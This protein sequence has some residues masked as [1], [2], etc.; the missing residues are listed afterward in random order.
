VRRVEE[1]KSVKIGDHIGDYAS[2]LTGSKD[3]Q[4]K[5]RRY[6]DLLAD[7]LGWSTLADL[8]RDDLDLWLHRQFENG[9]SARSCNGYRIAA[10]GFCTWL[11]EVGRLASNPFGRLEKFDEKAGS[12]RPRRAL[13]P[14]EL[15]RLMESAR[16]APKR[17]DLKARQ[18]TGRPSERF[19]GDDRVDLY[20]FLASTGLRL[21]EAR[22]LTVSDVRLNGALPGIDLRAITTK[23]KH[24]DFIPCDSALVEIVRRHVEGKKSGDVVFDIPADLIKRFH[25]DCKRAGIEQIDERGKRIDLHALR[26]T[27]GTRLAM[28]GVPLTVAQRLMRHSDPKLTSNLYTDVR[29]LDLHAAVGSMAPIVPKVVGKVVVTGGISCHSESTDVNVKSTGKRKRNAS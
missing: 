10:L 27:Y 25:A 5:T 28:A 14:E 24:K 15:S 20:G 6:L 21:N 7:A 9:R 29:L 19:S 3:H 17:P 16:I 18:T 12:R 8:R 1:T 11:V 13:T 26:K 23:N 22:L 4:K 2:T